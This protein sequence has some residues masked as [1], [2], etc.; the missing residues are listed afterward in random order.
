MPACCEYEREE[1]ES[2]GVLS[3]CDCGYKHTQA[4][5]NCIALYG[6]LPC[7]THVWHTQYVCTAAC[8][9]RGT[10]SFQH[11]CELDHDIA[12]VPAAPG[13]RGKGGE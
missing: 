5:M 13:R 10:R 2:L 4:C 9:T 7:M 3:G 1:G 8:V 6:Y 11:M 12:A